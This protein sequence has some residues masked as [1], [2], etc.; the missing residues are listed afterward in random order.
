MSAETVMA[1]LFPPTG[2]Q[3]WNS[4]LLWQPV[5][6]HTIPKHSDYL[7]YSR[8][9]CKRFSQIIERYSTSSEFLA[10]VSK[11]NNLTQYLE[12][13]TGMVIHNLTILHSLY[14]TLC[15]EQLKNKT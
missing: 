2:N 5:L 3:I 14:D 15:I 10:L 13:S 1:A 4:D 12:K 9:P 8:K 11:Y 7:L 6:I